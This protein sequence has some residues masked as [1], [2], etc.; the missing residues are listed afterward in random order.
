MIYLYADSFWIKR[1]DLLVQQLRNGHGR[2]F[3]LAAR[4][5]GIVDCNHRF[6]VFYG[7]QV[8]FE[9]AAHGLLIG[10]VYDFR[11]GR[12]GVEVTFPY[13]DQTAA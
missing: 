12:Q 3:P 8:R 9:F 5:I 1:E 10:R 6:G 11:T 2:S 4:I 7:L 13:H